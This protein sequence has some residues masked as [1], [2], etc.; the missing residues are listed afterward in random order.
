MSRAGSPENPVVEGMTDEVGA[1]VRVVLRQSRAK[2]TARGTTILRGRVAMAMVCAGEGGPRRVRIESDR[3]AL[4]QRLPELE[5]TAA[6]ERTALLLASLSSSL[7]ALP[8]SAWN[9]VRESDGKSLRLHPR[10]VRTMER[11]GP[12]SV[13]SQSI[14]FWKF[15]GVSKYLAV[16]SPRPPTC[17]T[18]HHRRGHMDYCWDPVENGVNDAF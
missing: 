6:T 13:R 5:L 18:S 8:E 16:S 4:A 17:N 1:V 10:A 11:E 3:V 15:A 2:K 12:L 14:T 9:S 7:S